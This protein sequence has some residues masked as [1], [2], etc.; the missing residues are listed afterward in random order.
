MGRIEIGGSLKAI[1]SVFFEEEIDSLYQSLGYLSASFEGDSVVPGEVLAGTAEFFGPGGE[2]VS[3]LGVAEKRL[4]GNTA[5]IE[6]DPT[7][8]LAINNGG[9]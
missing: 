4:G 6:T 2:E 3:Q 1:N 7:P 8:V 9:F 5:D